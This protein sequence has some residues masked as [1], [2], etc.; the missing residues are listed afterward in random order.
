MM[1]CPKFDDIELY[2]DKIE[3][4]CTRGD[5][6]SLTSVIME[7]P[8]CSGLHGLVRKALEA[9]GANIPLEEI[10]IDRRGNVIE[11]RVVPKPPMG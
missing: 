2:Q 3:Q 11:K 9:S 10:V 8:C 5:I 1:G 6:R 4:I 7:V